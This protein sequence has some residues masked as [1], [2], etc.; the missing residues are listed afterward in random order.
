MGSG[1]FVV[2]V[3]VLIG[4]GW[5]Q[6][7]IA[8]QGGLLMYVVMGVD[9]MGVSAMKRNQLSY[10]GCCTSVNHTLNGLQEL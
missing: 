4:D 10:V 8:V 3:S 9:P 7:S 5:D 1:T 2:F 6:E